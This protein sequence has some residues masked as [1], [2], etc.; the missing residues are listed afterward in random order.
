MNDPSAKQ[1]CN[2]TVHHSSFVSKNPVRS[3]NRAMFFHTSFASLCFGSIMQI[4]AVLMTLLWQ[5]TTTAEPSVVFI[6]LQCASVLMNRLSD[7]AHRIVAHTL[8]VAYPGPKSDD[9]F[10]ALG[11]LACDQ[12]GCSSVE[13]NLELGLPSLSEWRWCHE[14]RQQ[15]WWWHKRR[16]RW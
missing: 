2:F 15:W 4:S 7:G 10:L 8:Q 13:W 1:V 14:W 11:S 9:H 12:R 6:G 3:K 16:Q 5:T